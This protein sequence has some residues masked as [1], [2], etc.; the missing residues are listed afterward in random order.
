MDDIIAEDVLMYLSGTKTKQ[1]LA[2][3]LAKNQ[4]PFLLAKSGWPRVHRKALEQ[5]MG[6]CQHDQKITNEN[7]DFNFDAIR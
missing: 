7:V 3:W 5:A 6:V 2:L 4:V 1:R